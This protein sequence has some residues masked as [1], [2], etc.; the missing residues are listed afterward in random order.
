MLWVGGS[1][2]ARAS[3]PRPQLRVRVRAPKDR[4]ARHDQERATLGSPLLVE[5]DEVAASTSLV[6]RHGKQ[7]RAIR[8]T[9][10]TDAPGRTNL[11]GMRGELTLLNNPGPPVRLRGVMEQHHTTNAVGRTKPWGQIPVPLAFLGLLLIGSV[12]RMALADHLV[13]NQPDDYIIVRPMAGE[14]RII[15]EEPEPS[16]VIVQTAPPPVRFE[17]RPRRPYAGAIWVSGYWWWSGVSHAW[18]GGHY[19]RPIHGYRFVAPRWVFSGGYHYHIRGHY[20]P[21]GATVRHQPYHHYRQV[22]Y[23]GHRYDHSGRHRPTTHPGRHRGHSNQHRGHSKQHREYGNQHRGRSN[24][25]R[26]QS[27]HHRGST[28]DRARHRSRGAPY[29][30]AARRGSPTGHRTARGTVNHH[31]GNTEQRTSPSQRTAGHQRSARPSHTSQAHRGRGAG[32]T[33]AV[34]RGGGAHRG[35]GP[36]RMRH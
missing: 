6:G 30:P 1:T 27:I 21:Y 17:V 31:R 2:R 13:S 35:A 23:Y 34:S 25:H 29:T 22:G 11:P 15:I 26:D 4:L 19:V 36:T 18:I 3:R 16:W 32:S 24:Q 10:V 28:S 7:S 9:G 12:P 20:R 8:W 14:T 5:R 33:R